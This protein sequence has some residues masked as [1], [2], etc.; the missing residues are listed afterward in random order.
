[1]TKP[2]LKHTIEQALQAVREGKDQFALDL[3][4]MEVG[5]ILSVAQGIAHAEG[6]GAVRAEE[7]LTLGRDVAG[8]AL[9]I[10]PGEIGIA[11]LG[12][13]KKLKA[14]DEVVRTGRVLDVP[15]GNGLIGRVVNPLGI[16][17]DGR[18]SIREEE[19]WPV[20][21]EAPPILQRS[22][23]TKPLQTGLKV[24]DTLI[25]IGRGQRELI[26]GDRQTGKTAIALDTIC[27]Q[28]GADVICIYCAI[29]QRSSSVARVLSQMKKRGAME[30]SFAVVVEGDDQPG[31]QYIAPYAAT[32]MG[33]FFMKQ[34]RDV[35]VVYDDLTRHAQAYRQLS[36]LLRRPP[37]REAFPGDIFFIHSRLLERATHLKP[38]LGGGS[39]TALPII[40]TEEQNISAYIPTNLISIT[41]GQIYLNPDLFQRGILPAVDVGKSVSRVGGRAQLAGYRKV[42]AALRLTYSQFQELEAF[43]RF[44]TRLDEETRS[45]LEHGKR[46]REILKQERFAPLT[47]GEQVAV[48]LAVTKGSFDTLPLADI[49]ETQ[50][51]VIDALNGALGDTEQLG[52]A[53]ADNPIWD[54]ASNTLDTFFKSKNPEEA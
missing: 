3:Q 18:G 43:A 19:R 24:I 44:G 36:L 15:V 45:K 21:Q 30:Y 50:Q 7:L 8:M 52:N 22:P 34:G 54:K 20:E 35:L 9:D 51:H 49:N 42:A 28:K 10:L 29:G 12:S 53:Q 48:L 4:A 25:P 6:V 2:S 38:E 1:M 16:P 39:L 41:D 33:E 27:N 37:G 23:V 11:L 17:L 31:M 5:R 46:V 32:A 26:L 13:G 47:P 14:G 40:E